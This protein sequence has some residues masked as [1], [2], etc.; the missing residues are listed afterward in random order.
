MGNSAQ[1]LVSLV[2][3]CNF[4]HVF[5][6]LWHPINLLLPTPITWFELSYVVLL[7]S[8]VSQVFDWTDAAMKIEHIKE[9][10][11]I[12]CFSFSLFLLSRFLS[13]FVLNVWN[14]ICSPLKLEKQVISKV[15]KQCV[16]ASLCAISHRLRAE[17]GEVDWVC[18]W[19]G[20]RKRQTWGS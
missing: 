20:E 5:S 4:V 18:E 7:V 3:I 2:A 14:F 17:K 12:K 6:P 1:L 16:V 10:L 19:E 9:F 13:L 8:V 15:I 11:F